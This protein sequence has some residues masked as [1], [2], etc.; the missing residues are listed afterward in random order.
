MIQFY[1]DGTLYDNPNGW[2]TLVDRIYYSEDVSGYLRELNGSL[3]FYG[4]AYE[5]LRT[6]FDSGICDNVNVII[7]DTCADGTAVNIFEG[8]IFINDIEWNILKC[9]ATL[10][11][12]DN[13]YIA[14]IFNNKAIQCYLGV[15][16]S[17]NNVDISAFDNPQTNISLLD[18]T[19]GAGTTN[20]VGYR[21]YDAFRFIIAFIT[22]GEVYVESDF[23]N[24]STGT[25]YHAYYAVVMN[26]EEIRTGTATNYAYLSFQDFYNDI[27]KIY[28]IAFSF[29]KNSSGNNV[30]RIEPK[31]Y[32]K[33]T[34]EINYFENPADLIQ[35]INADKN[36]S[37]V[38]FG[39]A[40][41]ST[42]FT[43][44]QDIKFVGQQQEEY[45]LLGTCNSEAELDLQL[46]KLITDT[47]IIQYL[48]DVGTND[49]YDKNNFLICLGAL[50]V[51]ELT[52]KPLALTY[53]YNAGINNLS[54]SQY[55]F[56]EIPASIALYLAGDTNEFLANR[57][58]SVQ[59]VNSFTTGTNIIF[60]ND[61]VSPAFDNG[62]NYSTVTGAYTAPVNGVY[63]FHVYM[64]VLSTS[65]IS[66]QINYFRLQRYNSLNVLQETVNLSSSIP[67]AFNNY[68]TIDGYYNLFMY[69][70]D[71]VVVNWFGMVDIQ[72]GSYFECT[73]TAT[74]GATYQ[75]YQTENSNIIENDIT[76][77]ISC[78]QW[79]TIKSTPFK[80][81]TIDYTGGQV[82][83]WLNEISRNIKTGEA[84]VIINSKPNG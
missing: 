70:N 68:Y 73:E 4:A 17:K 37:K 84:T 30:M 3:T 14:K 13:S 11:I 9:S 26:G 46:T 55:W 74:G 62:G 33:Q 21:I 71:Y 61:T 63:G 72:I 1:L 50:N 24:A 47:N 64:N 29:E 5:Y 52:L 32:Y 25:D 2:E 6:K 27:N 28:N 81:F 41:V 77:Q 59:S 23:F 49:T 75:N 34:P 8:I 12:V 38:K 42:D 78:D 39:S 44:L 53:Y 80:T 56:G 31:S 83:G 51:V 45:H 19:G 15:N 43:Y 35:K 58:T 48:V 76:H 20:A 18:S 36:Y 67:M 69:Q 7:T 10:E 65:P 82:K 79:Q 40:Q 22:D 60:N 66:P 16:R 54:V 57:S